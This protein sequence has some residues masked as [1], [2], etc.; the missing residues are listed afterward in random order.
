M[1]AKI[2]FQ[3]MSQIYHE[4]RQP[5]SF[6]ISHTYENISGYISEK[7]IFT[8][9]L[10][11]PQFLVLKTNVNISVYKGILCHTHTHTKSNVNRSKWWANTKRLSGWSQIRNRAILDPR[12][13]R[14]ER[15]IIAVQ[16]TFEED[17]QKVRERCVQI[18]CGS[19]IFW[20]NRNIWKQYA[21]R[22]NVTNLST[23]YRNDS[24]IKNIY[25]RI[26]QAK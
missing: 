2:G 5:E 11:W 25:L 19:K 15:N 20:F 22:L 3:H 26:P 16:I 17:R 12:D 13:P 21:P 9:S 18:E 7:L 10:I 6:K 4:N 1:N 24:W 14:T 8:G 23:L